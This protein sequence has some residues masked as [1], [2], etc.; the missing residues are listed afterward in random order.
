M[1]FQG[2]Q[3]LTFPQGVEIPQKVAVKMY[4]IT[5]CGGKIPCYLTASSEAARITRRALRPQQWCVPSTETGSRG[6]HWLWLRPQL[7]I[8]S[9]F[10][11]N[12][13]LQTAQNLCLWKL[14]SVNAKRHGE[15]GFPHELLPRNIC[16]IL[17]IRACMMEN[18][19]VIL[20]CFYEVFFF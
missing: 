1:I 17:N 16:V 3:M 10:Q 2:R 14:Q 18:L 19:A 4:C 15:N 9:S 7:A 20:T 13:G 6:S 11:I 8:K 12:T 5:W